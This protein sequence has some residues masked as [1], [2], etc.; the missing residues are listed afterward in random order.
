MTSNGIEIKVGIKKIKDKRLKIDPKVTGSCLPFHGKQ[1]EKASHTL[2]QGKVTFPRVK[3]AHGRLIFPS[4]LQRFFKLLRFLLI[5]GELFLRPI[6]ALVSSS[7]GAFTFLT[8][9][10]LAAK[11][12]PGGWM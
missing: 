6:V 10:K 12:P 3:H 9:A 4:T 7:I 1:R 2:Q 11:F 5:L 8:H